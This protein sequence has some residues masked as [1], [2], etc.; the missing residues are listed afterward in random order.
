LL[1][2]LDDVKQPPQ[3]PAA[4][5]HQPA[6]I[7]RDATFAWDGEDKDADEPTPTLRNTDLQVPD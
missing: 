6:I 3:L 7:V 4:E 1:A 5:A 2:Q